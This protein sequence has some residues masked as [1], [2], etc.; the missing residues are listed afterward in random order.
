M[1]ESVQDFS[2]SYNI[3]LLVLDF[4]MEPIAWQAV[5]V[6]LRVQFTHPEMQQL[7]SLPFSWEVLILCSLCQILLPFLTE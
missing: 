5:I 1:Q 3:V 2:F 4:G 7:Y 6:A